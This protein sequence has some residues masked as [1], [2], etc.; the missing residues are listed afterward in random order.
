MRMADLTML[1][2]TLENTFVY[3]HAN[4]H[5]H[6]VNTE[7]KGEG[8]KNVKIH[9]EW[10]KF[11][12][13]LTVFHPIIEKDQEMRVRGN[14]PELGNW[15]NSLVMKKVKKDYRWLHNK[16]GETVKPYE[17]SVMIN[18]IKDAPMNIKYNY[19]LI[20]GVR[21]NSE[22]ERDPPRNLEICSPSSVG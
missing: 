16:Y 1:P 7:Y 18:N 14:I 15:K 2:H 17:I 3:D 12:L 10:E 8:P 5:N 4:Y 9:D 22:M 11:E 21:K 13:C 19:E 6:D 20:S